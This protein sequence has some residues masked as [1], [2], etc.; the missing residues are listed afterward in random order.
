MSEAWTTLVVLAILV[1]WPSITEAQKNCTKGIPCGNSCIS[2][3]KVCRINSSSRSSLD[4]EGAR[5]PFADTAAARGRYAALP[6][7][8]VYYF[9]TCQAAREL[10][11]R[12][13]FKTEQEARDSGRMPSRVP[14]C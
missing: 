9:T 13:Y 3:S 7:G 14:G 6:N 12:I 5:D 1:G 11:E 2:A 4:T 10:P 8:K